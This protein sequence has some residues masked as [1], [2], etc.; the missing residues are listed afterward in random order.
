MPQEVMQQEVMPQDNAHLATAK[1]VG[2]LSRQDGASKYGA[3]C[4]L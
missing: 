2:A 1:C 4:C 3:S